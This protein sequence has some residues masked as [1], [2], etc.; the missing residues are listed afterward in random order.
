MKTEDLKEVLRLHAKYLLGEADG[1]R[2]DLRSV[3]LRR[4]DLCGALLCGANLR[5]ADLCG[6]LL[7]DAN[8]WGADLRSAK[9]PAFQ[10]C[11]E[12]GDFIAWK[13]VTRGFVLKLL[14]TG[15]RISTP[16]GRKCRTNECKVLAAYDKEGNEVAKDTGCRFT[17]R[18]ENSFTYE[19]GTY[20]L[21]PDLDED[22]RVE[23][24]RGIHFFMTRK[25][26]ELYE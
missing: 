6:A 5:S 22:I 16:I 10:I 26:A 25:E 4:A 15:K 2:A 11:P 13:K 18:H 17:S 21:E 3:N 20:A 23:C 14:I 8:L 1:K 12:E 7:Y 24:T 19:V 9:L